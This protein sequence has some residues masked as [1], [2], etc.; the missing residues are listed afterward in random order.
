MATLKFTCTENSETRVIN[1]DFD[2]PL[3]IA[4]QFEQV[5]GAYIERV[6]LILSGQEQIRVTKVAEWR[7]AVAGGETTEGFE[8]WS[9]L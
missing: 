1:V 7:K 5:Q 2:L 4:K 9:G 8:E 6:D 3:S